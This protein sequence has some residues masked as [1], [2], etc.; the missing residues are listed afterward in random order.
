MKKKI[1][2]FLLEKKLF[3]NTK[4]F[5]FTSLKRLEFLLILFFI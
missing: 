4:Y 3:M 2:L 5:T 1:N